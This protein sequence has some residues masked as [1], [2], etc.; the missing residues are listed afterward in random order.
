MIE[1]EERAI[2]ESERQ[3]PVKFHFLFGEHGT[4]L[5]AAKFSEEFKR[6]DIVA[7][8]GVGWDD[9][10]KAEIEGI[11]EG[12]PMGVD[13]DFD[14]YQREELSVLFN[15]KKPILLIDVPAGDPLIA[16]LVKSVIHE[17]EAQ[18]DFEQGR[19]ARSMQ[20]YERYL[21]EHGEV[22]A[23]REQYVETQLVQLVQKEISENPKLQGIVNEKG[24]LDVAVS[25]GAA[26]TSLYHDLKNTGADADQKFGEQPFIFGFYAEALR[27]A[28]LGLEIP[29][30]LVAKALCEAVMQNHPLTAGKDT[31][32]YRE[33]IAKATTE[34]IKQFSMRLGRG[35]NFDDLFETKTQAS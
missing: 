10:H 17:D 2:P 25:F 6:A 7:I 23:K 9:K 11:S 34:E 4:S 35:E 29:D 8:E 31:I 5:D 19:F 32:I 1:H 27:R 28:R 18:N 24:F 33:I 30:D 26:H 15:S 22:E 3:M 21:I 12:K 13:S 16:E 20:L 14:S